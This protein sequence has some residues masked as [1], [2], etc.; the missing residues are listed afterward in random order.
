MLFPI[1]DR[2]PPSAHPIWK[3]PGLSRWCVFGDWMHTVDLGLTLN[4][5][6]SIMW[7]LVFEG[8]GSV[9]S[10]FGAMWQSILRTYARLGTRHRIN[11]MVLGQFWRPG[12]YAALIR[13]KAAEARDL[14]PVMISICEAAYDNSMRDEHRLRVLF[15]ID[16]NGPRS[17]VAAAD[18]V[19]CCFVAAWRTVLLTNDHPPSAP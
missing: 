3:I 18:H 10:N 4:L 12:D 8:P 6:G 17:C 14:V 5:L 15:L 13:V 16:P 9:R 2:T 19:S 11:N 7:E 1:H